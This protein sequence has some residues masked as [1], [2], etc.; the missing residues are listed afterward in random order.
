MPVSTS[1]SNLST[2]NVWKTKPTTFPC[3]LYSFLFFGFFL[4]FFFLILKFKQMTQQSN[5]SKCEAM[6]INQ[7]NAS[8]LWP[9]MTN[10]NYYTFLIIAI[11]CVFLN[12]FSCDRCQWN[13][14]PKKNI[15]IA[16]QEYFVKNKY[17][18]C[19]GVL[20]VLS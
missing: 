9:Q 15:Y 11:L 5:S 10:T 18:V 2:N 14:M 1:K 3:I 12:I 16:K 19:F 13:K 17:I 7:T 20:W 8:N 6:L 4:F